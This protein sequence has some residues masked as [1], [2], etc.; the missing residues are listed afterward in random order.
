M[1][2][3]EGTVE[4]GGATWRFMGGGQPLVPGTSLY[5]VFADGAPGEIAL[6]FATEPMG[7]PSEWRVVPL[8]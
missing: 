1:Q 3:M 7:F 6:A 2:T 8:A 4:L 5:V